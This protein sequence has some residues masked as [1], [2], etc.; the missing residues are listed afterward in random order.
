MHEIKLPAQPFQDHLGQRD[1]VG[2]DRGNRL[3]R[4]INNVNDRQSR[5]YPSDALSFSFVFIVIC[6]S[7]GGG[8]RF[9]RTYD[10][11]H[12]ISRFD[13]RSGSGLL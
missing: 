5:V 13:S 4:A 7:A 8:P 3:Q 12:R 1:A 10:S 6:P 2:N 11:A 9:L